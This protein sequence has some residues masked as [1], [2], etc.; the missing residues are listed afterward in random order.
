MT[1]S[2][3]KQREIKSI[4]D[5]V[6]LVM[7]QK[8]EAE[9]L[10]N[11]SDLLF[12]GQRRDW[13]LLPRLGRLSLRGEI[14][15]IEKLILEEFKRTSLP[16][17]EF[18]PE[19]D[20][21]VLA[22]AQHHGLPTRLLDWTYSALAGLW[23]A[24][25]ETPSKDKNGKEEPGVVWILKAQVEDF[26]L[27]T[28]DTNPLSNYTTKI[29]RSKIVS[30]RISAQSGV[31]TVHKINSNGKMIKLHKHSKYSSKLL[32]I[33]I[34]PQYFSK[35]RKDLNILGVNSSMVFPDLD[36]LCKHLKWRYS[37]FDDESKKDKDETQLVY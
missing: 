17:T 11:M 10:G 29:Y 8:S 2:T 26:K 1:E 33:M 15:N 22:L 36:G 32:K 7:E 20:W 34:L 5:Y 31:F 28:S 21:D 37:Y 4:V 16:L 35:L 30:R 6:A 24:V 14:N 18:K 13:E 25:N 12:R 19:N 27:E 23:F 3:Y 9:K